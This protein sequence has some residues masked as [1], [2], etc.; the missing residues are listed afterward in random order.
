MATKQYLLLSK[1]NVLHANGLQDEGLVGIP[2][3][4]QFHGFLDALNLYLNDYIEI[5][6]GDFAVSHHDHQFVGARKAKNKYELRSFI[7][8]RVITNYCDV[9]CKLL[10]KGFA[11]GAS[12]SESWLVNMCVSLIIEVETYANKDEL[13][14]YIAQALKVLPVCG[15]HFTHSSAYNPI[16]LIESVDNEQDKT[17]QNKLMPGQ[18]AK[19]RKDL[20]LEK[21][22]TPL[23]NMIE[24]IVINPNAKREGWLVPMVVGLK[25]LGECDETAISKDPTKKHYYAETIK[26]M[27]EMRMPIRF[28]KVDDF[29][30]HY[31]Y[32]DN[33]YIVTN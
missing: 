26:T 18:V 31:E 25:E 23:E 22:A 28:D 21:N 14:F 30:W 13:D 33:K 8:S 20:I 9:N 1:L 17:I 12:L 27:C 15:G 3:M 2:S 5:K 24:N 11:R 7:P 32:K 4:M 19:L 10:K 16:E 6:F 29:M